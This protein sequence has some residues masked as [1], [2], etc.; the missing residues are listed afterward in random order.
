MIATDV[1]VE[2]LLQEACILADWGLPPFP[3]SNKKP[4]CRWKHF[5][6]RPPGDPEL[7]RLVRLPGVDGIGVIPGAG[8]GFA[9]RDFD[10]TGA[11]QHWALFHPELAGVAPTVRTSRGF[12]VWV[13]STVPLYRKCGDG[14]FLGDGRH[15]VVTPPS[16]HPSGIRYEWVGGPPL[17][18]SAFP[19]VNPHHAGLLGIKPARD[20]HAVASSSE[21]PHG[22]RNSA[23][24]HAEWPIRHSSSSLPSGLP[25]PGVELPG[26]V[27]ECVLRTLP[28]RQ[29]QRNARL[30]RFAQALRGA[31]PDAT[32]AL[33][34]D[35]VTAWWRLALPVIGTKDFGTTLADFRR[36]WADAEV[37]LSQSRPLRAMARGVAKAGTGDRAAVLLSLCRELARE[38]G[39]EFFLS[40]RT[41]AEKSGIPERTVRRLL[42]RLVGSGHLVVVKKGRPSA[43]DRTGTVVYRLGDAGKA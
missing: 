22:H 8:N 23:A 4:R 10:D 37:P 6:K 5:Q 15:Y 13:R 20:R 3:L 29:G 38:V 11:Y 17:G 43:R 42:E 21:E 41:A 24:P 30:F 12:H 14:E 40:R 18:P 28:T 2:D 19:L 35:A 16:R 39:C 32:P 33:L 7:W 27:R 9:V 34:H 1:T 36:A 31:V 26:V 25:D